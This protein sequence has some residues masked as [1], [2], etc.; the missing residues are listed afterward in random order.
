MLGNLNAPDILGINAPQCAAR[1]N[2]S[3][4][5]QLNDSVAPAMMLTILSEHRTNYQMGLIQR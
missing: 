5:Y 3:Q 1:Q 4:S 2:K